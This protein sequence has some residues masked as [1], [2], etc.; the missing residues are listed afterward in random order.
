MINNDVR[1]QARQLYVDGLTLN[2]IAEELNINNKTVS[3][4]KKDMGDWDKLRAVHSQGT[5]E[6][7]AHNFLAKI[8]YHFDKAM[9]D[10]ESGEIDSVEKA[11]VLCDLAD[12]FARS[13]NANKKLMPDVD[14]LQVSL[15]VIDGLSATI[16]KHAPEIVEKYIECVQI[17]VE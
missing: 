7:L 9:Q 3:A 15:E 2:Q 13:V 17:Y 4:W 5:T 8:M 14:K 12:S 16:S 1:R 10:V 6:Q 11:R